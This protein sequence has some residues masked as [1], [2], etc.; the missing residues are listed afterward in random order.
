MLTMFLKL[1]FASSSLFED[2]HSAVFWLIFIFIASGHLYF[3]MESNI[4]LLEHPKYLWVSEDIEWNPR[5]DPWLAFTLSASET[6]EAH[7]PN[8]FF[9]ESWAPQ[10]SAI[11]MASVDLQSRGLHINKV[12]SFLKTRHF[13]SSL[14]LLLRLTF[15]I[16]STNKGKTN[17]QTKKLHTP[18][19]HQNSLHLQ[20]ASSQPY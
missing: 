11:H 13:W 1:A 15:R 6:S 19:I 5:A 20:P 12:H 3:F 10:R 7:P 8:F 18:L 16:T 9:L 14:Q 17:K 4:W 2:V